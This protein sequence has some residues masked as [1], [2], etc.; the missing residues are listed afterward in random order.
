MEALPPPA[1]LTALNTSQASSKLPGLGS[2]GGG[3]GGA[4]AGPNS[5]GDQA[6]GEEQ[7]IFSL[8]ILRQSTFEGKHEVAVNYLVRINNVLTRTFSTL[9]LS[10]GENYPN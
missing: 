2:A 9:P 7:E 4:S 3:A 1:S 6:P 5:S 8:L 10:P